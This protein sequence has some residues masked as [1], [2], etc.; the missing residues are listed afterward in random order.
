MPQV[1]A[2]ENFEYNLRV[3]IENKNFDLNTG[4]VK[5]VSKWWKFAIPATAT[6]AAAIFIFTLSINEPESLENPFQIAPQPLNELRGAMTESGN[7]QGKI[8]NNSV[9]LENDVVLDQ[10][11]SR[12]R[13]P[14]LSIKKA[15]NSQIIAEKESAKPDF[16]FDNSKSTDLD[17]VM[18]Q[19]QNRSSVGGTA[20]LAGRNQRNFFN[21]FFIGEEVNKEYVDSLK[22]RNDSLMKV[23]KNRKKMIKEAE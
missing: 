1:K 20:S 4:E 17:K 15:E 3:K 14:K 21:G 13:E 18:T 5:T 10:M 11:E 19:N 9:L 8:V 12:E 22:A 16:P 2:P 23:I 6:T 7:S